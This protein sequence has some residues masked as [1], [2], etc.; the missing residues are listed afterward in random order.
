MNRVT[1][2]IDGMTC[3]HCVTGVTKAL[4]GIN[5]VD[6]GEVTIGEARAAYDPTVVS[7]VDITRA[8]E[9][10]GYSVSSISPDNGDDASRG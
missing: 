10:E 4:K 8:I 7:N 9:A 1:V 3:G 5:G 6:V 2:K